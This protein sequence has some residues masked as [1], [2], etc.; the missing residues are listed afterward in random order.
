MEAPSQ[1]QE[2]EPME[3]DQPASPVQQQQQ[4]QEQPQ[5]PIQEQQQQPAPS[6]TPVVASRIERP[7][8]PSRTERPVKSRIFSQA[9]GDVLNNGSRSERSSRSRIRS[10]SRSRSPPRQSHRYDR[11]DRASRHERTVED[12]N[13][14][15]RI[16]NAKNEERPSVFDRLGGSRANQI[17]SELSSHE[18]R[19][20]RREPK[21][22]R[23]KYWPTC[24]KGKQ[25]PFFHPTRI[26]P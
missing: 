6:T 8:I 4:Q 26:C 12:R 3:Q 24:S 1:E 16:G 19:E 14:F 5:E 23:C 22:E 10:R 17:K 9:L 15:S 25:C 11:S 7:V 13:V 18:E 20:V 21:R 2:P